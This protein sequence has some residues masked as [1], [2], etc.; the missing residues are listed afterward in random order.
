M[1]VPGDVI[2]AAQTLCQARTGARTA[3]E[4]RIA[5]E[6]APELSTLNVET[7]ERVLL[8]T[9]RVL[10][11]PVVVDAL[12]ATAGTTPASGVAR[13]DRVLEWIIGGNNLLGIAFLELGTSPNTVWAESSSAS[14]LRAGARD[15]L[16]DFPAPDPDDNH[17]LPD[18]LSARFSRLEFNFQDGVS[19]LPPTT[20]QFGLEP[21]AS[22]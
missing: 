6:H 1:A 20:S 7:P 8:R 2:T 3:P 5:S 17:V 4:Q 16:H 11:Q 21:D 13:D 15:R 14:G 12:E 10:R 9:R 19:G 22:P 18:D